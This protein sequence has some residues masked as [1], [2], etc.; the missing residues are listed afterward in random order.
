MPDL[1]MSP[2]NREKMMKPL[3][4]TQPL[5]ISK[6]KSDDSVALEN[7]E[8]TEEARDSLAAQLETRKP[9]AV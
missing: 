3:H 2:P 9:I 6:I 4:A 7:I 1:L 8:A 5:N